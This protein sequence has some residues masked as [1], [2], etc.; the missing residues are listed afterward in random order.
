MTEKRIILD[1]YES[2]LSDEDRK[3]A[4]EYARSRVVSSTSTVATQ[5]PEMV[6]GYETSNKGAE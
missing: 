1:E 3:V 5:T 6:Q 4:A 2:T